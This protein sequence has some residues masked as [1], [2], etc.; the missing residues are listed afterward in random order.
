MK[1]YKP[2]HARLLYIDREIG[3]G[4]YPNHRPASLMV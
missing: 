2:Q 1:K 4:G 3:R